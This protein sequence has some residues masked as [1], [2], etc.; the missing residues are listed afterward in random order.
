MHTRMHMDTPITHTCRHAGG[1]AR[2]H[3]HRN[4]AHART[5]LHT[6][7]HTS[8]P[9]TALCY[10]KY[11]ALGGT[12]HFRGKP[13]PEVYAASVASLTEALG[14]PPAPE[15]MCAVGDSL[16][17]DIGGARALGIPNVWIANGV[18]C[19]ELGTQEGEARVPPAERMRALFDRHRIV[20]LSVM[21]SFRWA[22]PP[23]MEAARSGLLLE[24]AD[25][26]LANMGMPRVIREVDG[27]GAERWLMYCQGREAD[28][29][30]Q[31]QLP[32]L[33][34]GRIFRLTRSSCLSSCGAA[35]LH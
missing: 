17:H 3:T 21:P 9:T 26:G 23:S 11:Q 10:S 35:Y 16:E 32:N 14:T 24:P 2:A 6:H 7:V 12:V 33:S 31:K 5:Q 13:H 18:H 34:T 22:P 1:C 20:P 8:A 15:R 4:T 30:P 27:D 19:A 29:D 25:I 28:F